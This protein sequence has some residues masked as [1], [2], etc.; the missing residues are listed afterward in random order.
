MTGI[1][2]GL[3]I[4]FAACTISAN[5]EIVQDRITLADGHELQV[6]ISL[7]KKTKTKQKFPAYLLFGGFETAGEILTLIP[8]DVPVIIASF[9]YPFHGERKFKF[10]ETLLNAPELKHSMLE[11]YEGIPKLVTLLRNRLDVDHDHIG[12]I[13]ASFGAPFAITS[14]ARD[15]NIKRLVIVHGFADIKGTIQHRIDQVLNPKLGFASNT[16]AWMTSSVIMGY[17]NPPLPEN[18]AAKLR[19]DQK[20]LM[21]EAL[22]DRFIPDSSRKLLWDSLNKSQAKIQRLQWRGEHLQPGAEALIRKT[23]QAVLDWSKI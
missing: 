18:S 14:A 2:E 8:K 20:V 17:F 4:F 7:P 12:I 23:V 13:G 1:K 22:D 15:P 11:T 10:P 9:D 19:A 5:A 16:A 21:I 6:K 3:F